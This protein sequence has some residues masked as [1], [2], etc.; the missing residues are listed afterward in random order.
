[1]STQLS[2][3]PTL[4]P[5]DI[6]IR[7]SE[8]IEKVATSKGL[9]IKKHHEDRQKSETEVVG[10]YKLNKRLIEAFGKVGFTFE[11][12]RKPPHDTM[13]YLSGN[14]DQRG[15]EVFESDCWAWKRTEKNPQLTVYFEL[16]ASERERGV[17]AVPKVWGNCS[18]GACHRPTINKLVVAIAGYFPDVH[19]LLKE[20]TT[21]SY[22]A[23][24]W[25]DIGLGGVRTVATLFEELRGHN[26]PVSRLAHSNVSPFL[27][28]PKDIGHDYFVVE[29]DQPKLFEQWRRQLREYKNKLG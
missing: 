26:E 8:L 23:I 19:P 5:A 7:R 9:I 12:G 29:S 28:S 17:I 20:V 2:Q 25:S 24:Y 14:S 18:G 1:V 11:P 4:L 27:P 3:E 13:I 22:P 10:T 21:D 16:S 15:E 6:F